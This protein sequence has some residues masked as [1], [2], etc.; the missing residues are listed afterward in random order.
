MLAPTC[1][2]LNKDNVSL[3]VAVLEETQ[4]ETVAG[5]VRLVTILNTGD[6]L[7]IAYVK[8]HG[9]RETNKSKVSLYSEL[10]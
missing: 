4:N 1:S 6:L 2:F 9:I 10:L 5:I 8:V 3:G 7:G